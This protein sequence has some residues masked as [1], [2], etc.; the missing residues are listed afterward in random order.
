MTNNKEHLIQIK[1]EYLYERLDDIE[2]QYNSSQM[3]FIL[4]EIDYY[5][6]E[7]L[8]LETENFYRSLD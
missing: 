2:E 3:D 8:K 1:L 6:T 7:L 5:K 4:Q